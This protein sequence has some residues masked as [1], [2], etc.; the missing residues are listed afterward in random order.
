MSQGR[1]QMPPVAAPAPVTPP[2]PVAAPGRAKLSP[3][4]ESRFQRDMREGDGYKQWREGFVRKYGEEPNIEDPDYDYRAAWKNGVRP[5]PY[6]HD[7]DVYHWASATPDGSMLKSENH[8]TAWMEYFMRANGGKD[9][10]DVGVSSPAE[11]VEY[12][13]KSG[14]ADAESL[15]HLEKMAGG[16]GAAPQEDE[17]VSSMGSVQTIERPT[18]KPK[19]NIR[20]LEDRKLDIANERMQNIPELGDKDGLR[21]ADYE[22]M[23]AE[24]ER[25]AEKSR[26]TA[27]EARRGLDD[28]HAREAEYRQRADQLWKE[29]EANRQPPPD[30]TVTKVLG[31]IGS[32]L[33]MA[34]NK[35]GTA[36]GVQ[37]LMGMLGK[38]KERWAAEREANSKLYQQALAQAEDER[39]GQA[40]HLE[41]SQK[42]AALEAHEISDVLKSVETMG[43][44]KR[45]TA[46]SQELLGEFQ[47]KVL[48][49]LVVSEKEKQREQQAAAAKHASQREAAQRDALS[50]MSEEQLQAL[51]A[52][53][54]L[55][56]LGQ[57]ILAA[58]IKN[59][60]SGVK[61]EADSLK[62]QNEALAA[63]E[64]GAKLSAD[65][66]KVQ[67]LLSG[68]APAV[69][70][71]RKMLESGEAPDHP[72]ARSAPDAVRSPEALNRQADIDAVMGILLRDESG[73]SISKDDQEVKIRGWGIESG[74]PDVRRRGLKK[75]MA[76]YES[77][78]TGKPT[79][80]DEGEKPQIQFKRK[81]GPN[82]AA[83]DAAREYLEARAGAGAGG[84]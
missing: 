74:D 23:A 31:I 75:M 83:G 55:G 68:V 7:K 51:M 63:G 27:A 52:Q 67:R 70:N 36:Q 39:A 12:L 71:I 64:P 57:Q 2:A 61:G 41:A 69:A 26:A 25:G 28:S 60:Q 77:R 8:P 49:G 82:G 21:Q 42:I 1:A 29:M 14:T 66:R 33:S 62:A 73:A 47:T 58:K 35:P 84:V 80:I 4:E 5:A 59:R 24:H 79:A 38:D 10:H 76:E 32:V 6:E 34:S 45:A 9:P 16:S 13:R 40:Q 78:L 54:G 20:E 37:M 72:W 3:E 15:G 43:L 19:Q 65:E 48:D 18:G 44:G 17:P 50:R 11:A 30:S 53:G 22:R 56:E 46:L 81:A